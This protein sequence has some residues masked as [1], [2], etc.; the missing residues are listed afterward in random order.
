MYETPANP[1]STTL[2][3]TPF[4]INVRQD[5]NWDFA[6]VPV[7]FD[8][9]G[10]IVSYMWASLVVGG[11]PV[12][13]FFIRALKPTIDTIKGDH[14]L[15]QD[16]ED[17]IAQEVQH[18]AAHLKLCRHLETIGYDVRGA[19]E[20]IDR[21]LQEMTAGLSPVDM[22]GVVAAGEHSLYAIAHMYIDTPA[23]REGMHP[24]VERL[25]SYHLL[26]E[27]E[28]GAVSHDQYRYFVGNNYWHRIRMA[29]RARYVFRLLTEVVGIFAKGFGHR[30]TI[31]DRATL[32]YYMW[33]HP[34]PIR[35]MLG[36][37]LSYM[38]PT[39]KMMFKHEDLRLLERW[40]D[41]LYAGQ[42]KQPT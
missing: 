3:Q 38:S 24:Q 35:R 36:S 18:A 8:R 15:K 31:K 39:Y 6:Q 4:R 14:K 19:T 1:P 21:L 17:M 37:L 9:A 41:D 29:W 5:L 42:P 33:V 40:N 2:S 12:E 13:R 27:A 11:P 23:L 28:H 10:V 30:I 7:Q 20:H 22:L 34:G 32:L 25:F 26:E 16:V